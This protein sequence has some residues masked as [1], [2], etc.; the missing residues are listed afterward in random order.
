MQ[1][2]LMHPDEQLA[3][4][5]SGDP[6]AYQALQLGW[7]SGSAW[8]RWTAYGDLAVTYAREC[9]QMLLTNGM[10]PD[11]ARRI[12]CAG[13][14]DGLELEEFTRQGYDAEGFDLYPEK[15]RVAQACGCKAKV[16]DIHDPPYSTGIYDCVFASHVLEHALDQPRACAALGALLRPEGVLFIVVPLEDALPLWNPSHTAFVPCPEALMQ[17]F[18]GWGVLEPRILPQRGNAPHCILMLRRPAVPA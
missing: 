5:Q 1:A 10:L 9:C 12:C 7:Q 15:V 11:T 18:P 3:L 4:A 14:S 13:C 16:G 2:A 17:H 6:A 8:S